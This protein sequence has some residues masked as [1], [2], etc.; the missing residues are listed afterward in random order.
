[1]IDD[2]QVK[3]CVDGYAE[4]VADGGEGGDGEV[5]VCRPKMNIPAFSSVNTKSSLCSL[6]FIP[7]PCMA[8]CPPR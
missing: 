6:L 8:T 5:E 1:M 2:S 7:G 4:V 3:T